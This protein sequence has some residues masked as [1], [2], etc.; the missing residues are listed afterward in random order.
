MLYIHTV[1]NN[2][3][4]LLAF[5]TPACFYKCKPTC[6]S[7]HKQL[8]ATPLFKNSEHA[9]AAEIN[10]G[11][12]CPARTGRVDAKALSKTNHLAATPLLGTGDLICPTTWG[13]TW[14]LEGN[15]GRTCGGSRDT[16]LA[17]DPDMRSETARPNISLKRLGD[18]AFWEI[19]G[20]NGNAQHQRR[21]FESGNC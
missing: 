6:T 21:R 18:R 20:G 19:N 7:K 10:S 11:A 17:N 3:T 14:V 5:K 2:Y 4:S 8:A 16:E 13:V 1:Q 15:A 9:P 12:A